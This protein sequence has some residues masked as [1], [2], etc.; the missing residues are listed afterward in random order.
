MGIG[1]ILMFIGG[2]LTIIA[3]VIL[4]NIQVFSSLLTVPTNKVA[5][6]QIILFFGILFDLLGIC[7]YSSTFVSTKKKSEKPHVVSKEE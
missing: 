2:L 4:G 5:T 3:G 7:H 1:I 6:F